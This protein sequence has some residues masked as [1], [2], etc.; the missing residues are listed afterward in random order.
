MIKKRQFLV[1]ALSLLI[2]A[3][4]YLTNKKTEPVQSV[5]N[6][7]VTESPKVYGEAQFVNGKGENLF[8]QARLTR[9]KARGEA[10]DLLREITQ[11]PES[12]ST[13]QNDAIQTMT[14]MATATEQEGKIENE[15]KAK[16]FGDAVVFITDAGASIS[17]ADQSFKEEEI[18]KILSVVVAETGLGTD[19]IKIIE[20]K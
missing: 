9:D 4:A 20:I 14:K 8:E 13:A 7:E 12:D 15:L 2:V 18:S 3:G 6:Q 1:V 16:G 19:K 10:L 11:N 5:M 17:L